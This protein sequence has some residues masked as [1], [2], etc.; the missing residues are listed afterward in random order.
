MPSVLSRTTPIRILFICHGNICRSTMAQFVMQDLVNKAGLADD[1]F[2][3]SAAT[4][5]EEIGM[6]PG[7]RTVQKLK[8]EG[9]PSLKH[10]AKQVKID[11]YNDFD[12]LICMDDKNIRN[13]TRI[14]GEDTDGKFHKLLEY[15][16]GNFGLPASQTP[17]IADPWYTG[18]FD[19]TFDQVMMGCK[20]L[21]KTLLG[22]NQ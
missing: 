12:Y 19:I 22:N 3:D 11:D 4:S 8:K 2:I 18:N 1:F 7:L 6:P 10:R 14:L 13:L 17:D 5:R 16:D 20:G 21:L 15:T 9:I